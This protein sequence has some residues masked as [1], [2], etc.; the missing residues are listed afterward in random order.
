M[1][2]FKTKQDAVKMA[3]QAAE[4]AHNAQ[5][6]PEA[7]Y[8]RG[9]AEALRDIADGFDSEPIYRMVEHSYRLSD[10]ARQLLNYF[11][12]DKSSNVEDENA[13]NLE[14]LADTLGAS[15]EE[16]TDPNNDAYILDVLVERFEDTSDCNEA[17]NETWSNVIWKFIAENQ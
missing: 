4:E 15:Y 8:L 16:L 7:E 14:T 12:I 9:R 6:T 10:T 3:E 13:Q 5:G 1:L 2:T 17:E 11:G